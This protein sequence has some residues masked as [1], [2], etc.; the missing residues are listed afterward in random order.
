MDS[1][2]IFLFFSTLSINWNSGIYGQ[3]N[4]FMVTDFGAVP[5]G[6]TD[7]SNA[8]ASAWQKACQTVGGTVSVPTGSF[9]LSRADFIGPCDGQTL[10]HTD[11]TLIASDDPT[12]GDR[13][14]WITFSYVDGL[15]IFGNGVFDGNG[16]LSWSRCHGIAN[17]QHLPPTT[18][19]ITFVTNA[20]IQGVHFTNSKM[21]HLLIFACEN[22]NIRN[23]HI[24]APEDSPNTDGIHIGDSDSTWIA[25]SYIGTGDDCVSIGQGSTNVNISGVW[26]GPGHGISI[27]SLGKYKE[28]RSV[29][30]VTVRNCTFSNTDNGLRIKTWAPSTSNVVSGVR[31]EDIIVHGVQNP[32]IID[33]FY[34]PHESCSHTGESSV[35]IKGV[36]FVNIRGSSASET[37]VSIRCSKSY[38]CQDIEFFGLN[39]TYKG[40]PTNALCAN[41]NH[42]FGGSNQI[43]SGCPDLMHESPLLTT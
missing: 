23:V 17:C 13:D 38:P 25:D 33:Q 9:F 42:K 6:R 21:F 43:P 30:E 24:S 37:S 3:S 19:K 41:A 1:Y 10:F 22:V 27:G 15:K 29:G 39:L 31:F 12:L 32:I 4:K 35:E 36:K 28:E 11:G 7:S 14:H 40:Q 2:L 5:D 20:S 16:A 34:C 18:L 26:C 8:F